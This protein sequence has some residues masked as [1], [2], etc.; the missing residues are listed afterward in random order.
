MEN[1]KKCADCGSTKNL[2]FVKK[3]DGIAVKW[4]C[5]ACRD[6]LHAKYS[7]GLQ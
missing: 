5:K 3:I 7:D 2:A 6:T 4:R 1:A